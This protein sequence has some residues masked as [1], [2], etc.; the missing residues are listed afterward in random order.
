MPLSDNF[1]RDVT[2]AALPHVDVI[3]ERLGVPHRSTGDEIDM[4]ATH[5][6]D[7]RFGSFRINR[8]SGLWSDFAVDGD[9][10]GD[11]ISLV[12]YLRGCRQIDAANDLAEMFGISRD[13]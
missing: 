1:F 9:A 3:L 2:E 12:A 7:R 4:I 6:G 10:G 8:R 5:R 13:G 11:V